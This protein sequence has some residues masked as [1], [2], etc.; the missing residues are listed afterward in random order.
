[1]WVAKKLTRLIKNVGVPLLAGLFAFSAF[2]QNEGV[3]AAEDSL[4]QA[5]NMKKFNTS[6]QKSHNP[7]LSDTNSIKTN[8]PLKGI[9]QTPLISLQQYIKGNAAGVFVREG[10]GEPGSEQAMFI[11][12]LATP[13][14]NRQDLY[15][16]QP[17][18]YLNGVPLTQDNAFTY[19]IQ[20]YDFNKIGSATNL[21]SMLDINNIGSI[22]ILKTPADLARLGPLASNGAIWVTTKNAKSLPKPLINVESYV[23]LLQ[24]PKVETINADYENS[25]RQPFYD[26][27]A[28][29]AQ[30]A[31]YPVYVR[32]SFDPN[33]YGPANW[34]DIYYKAK[35]IYYLGLGLLGGTDRANFRFNISDTKDRNF[36]ATTF[37]RYAIAFGINMVPL[38][39]LTISS[40]INVARVTRD[41]SRSLRD[42]FAEARFVPDLSNP[43]SP[44]KESYQSFLDK[45]R[46][47]IDKNINNSF[48]GSFVA[49]AKF[50]N[51]ELR[52]VLSMDY[53]E[54]H[55]NVFWGKPLMDDNSF[56]STY[57]GFNQR[58]SISNTASYTI[59]IAD[60]VHKV[61]LEAG[62][63]YVADFFKYDYVIAYNSPNDFIKVKEIYL[64]SSGA[65]A[66][67]NDMFGYPFS[68]NLKA[69]LSSVYGRVG[70]S[71]KN[72][73]DLNGVVKYDGYSSFSPTDRWLLTPAVSARV[74]VHESSDSKI[75]STIAIRASWGKFG[76]L[77]QDNRFRIGPQYRVDMGYSDEPVV[78]S[79][80][81]DPGLS[82][83]YSFGWIANYYNW[84]FSEKLN[85]GADLGF[86]KNSIM[87]GLDLYRNIDKNMI[88]PTPI[89]AENGFTYKY[90]QGMAV[91]NE[92]INFDLIA[93]VLN[94]PDGLTWTL[95]TNFS[96]NRNALVKLPYDLSSVQY[97]DKK[98]E[99]GKPVDSYWLYENLGIIERSE[100]VPVVGTTPDGGPRLLTFG[101]TSAFNGGDPLWKDVDGDGII[102]DR[103]KVL[104]GHSLPVYT[105]G[106]SNSFAYKGFNL[107]FQFYF[108][109][110]HQLLNQSTANKLDFI[111][112]ENSKDI[113]SIKE[114]TF[115]QKTFDYNDYPMYNPWSG[116]IPYRLDQDLFLQNAGYLKL[117]Y[118]SLGYD[119]IKFAKVH[120]ARV[121]K[122]LLYLSGNN[123]L[124]ISRFKE[125][126]PELV[127]YNG[128]YNGR[129]LPLVTSFSLGLKV[130]F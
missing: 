25:F 119:L 62:Q 15:S 34:N 72:I 48:V 53:E 17:V 40:N 22:E 85:V 122:A 125:G 66:N 99:I 76:K 74:N 130:N 4:I 126:D 42:R 29:E 38:Q 94:N 102:N 69:N 82:Q 104:K 50:N 21:L 8:I 77:I 118:A 30:K 39:W 56:L 95:N 13:L 64:N 78:G 67:R 24:A 101:G 49:T 26:Q 71:Y 27:Y 44:N 84:P 37:N 52:S 114:I 46:G 80:G 63:N 19:N 113:T 65:Y 115:W 51:L 11:R 100:D 103:D 6:L 58:G 43:L 68:D 108:G 57:F 124:T 3:D 12:G 73:I 61:Q 79:Y 116:V 110:G 96:W 16:V 2:A 10:D 45:Y 60:D 33:Y 41:R 32:N 105:G 87:L 112:S 120:S 91:K 1:M 7:S 75:F 35:P 89:A 88:V 86:L 121:T 20:R 14:F 128:I 107:D 111:N 23:G 70:Y 97:G 123:L 54:S 90:V 55:R 9:S 81:G 28:T 109:V 47:S 92:G 59:P 129:S 36:D 18:V 31:G 93:D 98:I 117:R 127:D 83:P 5:V 106:L